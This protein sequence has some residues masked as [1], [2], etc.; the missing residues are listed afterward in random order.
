MRTEEL[1]GLV[2]AMDITIG[3]SPSF[4]EM[5]DWYDPE[6][7][8]KKINELS[9]VDEEVLRSLQVVKDIQAAR[10]DMQKAQMEM[11]QVQAGADAG[12]KIAQAQS[13]RMGAI[14]GRP[15]G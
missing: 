2:Q 5:A 15:K 8:V 13:M 3:A 10:A 7:V 12:M 9:G 11:E 14:S 6:K 4:P 1:Q